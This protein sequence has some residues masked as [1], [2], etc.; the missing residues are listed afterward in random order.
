M[1][2]TPIEPSYSQKKEA[3]INKSRDIIRDEEFK[4][5]HRTESQFFT[6]TRK[7]V[8]ELVVLMI[9][10]KS[11][12]SIQNLLNEFFQK[13]GNGILVTNSAFTQRRAQLSYTAFVELNKIAVV[14]VFYGD[15]QYR[16]FTSIEY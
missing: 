1:Y 16:T 14:E 7:L 2:E 5:R 10:Q 3:L 15:G 12:K 9:L 6:R 13:L 8:F 4:D 11:V